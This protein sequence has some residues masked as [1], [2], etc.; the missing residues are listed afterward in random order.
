MSPDKIQG[1]GK[2]LLY[3]GGT[4]TLALSSFTNLGLSKY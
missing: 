4:R 2:K 3:K 1:S